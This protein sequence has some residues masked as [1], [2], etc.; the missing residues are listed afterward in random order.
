[1]VDTMTEHD[2][3]EAP[4]AY[5]TDITIKGVKR[6]YLITEVSEADYVATFRTQDANGNR[7]PKLMQ[8]FNPR[9]IAKC[10]RREDG[11]PITLDEAKAM[12]MPLVQALVRAVLD[13]HQFSEDTDKAIENAEGN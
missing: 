9:V 8:T 3:F 1:M 13:V 4:T 7:D 11:T 12:R 6:T 10:V 5:P 2:D